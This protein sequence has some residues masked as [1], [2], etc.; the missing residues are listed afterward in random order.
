MNEET[1]GCWF[2]KERAGAIINELKFN[3]K[4]RFYSVYLGTCEHCN[5]TV[6]DVFASVPY[7]SFK[8]SDSIRLELNCESRMKRLASK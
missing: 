1:E 2:Y 3:P 8:A 4:S 7:K 6:S 5:R